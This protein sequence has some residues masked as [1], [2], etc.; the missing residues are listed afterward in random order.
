MFLSYVSS[1][2]V[3]SDYQFVPVF[4]Q[5]ARN[6]SLNSPNPRT[7]S[8]KICLCYVAVSIYYFCIILGFKNKL[9]LNS[10]RKTFRCDTKKRIKSWKR[11]RR[12]F[13]RNFENMRKKSSARKLCFVHYLSKYPKP[14][15][16]GLV[17]QEQPAVNISLTGINLHCNA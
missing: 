13:Q 2:K 3:T 4:Y 15:D 1:K 8:L 11:R 6:L 10:G 14:A 7:I 9:F 12:V 17:S 5:H 16:E